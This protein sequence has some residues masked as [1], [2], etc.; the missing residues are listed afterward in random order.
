MQAWRDRCLF[1]TGT[2]KLGVRR[3]GPLVLGGGGLCRGGDQ[4]LGNGLAC[5]AVGY[6]SRLQQSAADNNAFMR[7]PL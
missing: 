2:G 6:D 1:I 4:Q 5:G 7:I 3:M